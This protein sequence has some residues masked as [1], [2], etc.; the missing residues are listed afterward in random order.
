M[1]TTDM[2]EISERMSLLLPRLFFID[3]PIKLT[4]PGNKK[5]RSFG[6]GLAAL[7]GWKASLVGFGAIIG[8]ILTRSGDV[9]KGE[10]SF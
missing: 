4:S 1:L 9:G 3:A 6:D 5:L 8:A 2:R 7:L 10:M